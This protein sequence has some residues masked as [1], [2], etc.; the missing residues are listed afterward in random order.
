M[1]RSYGVAPKRVRD[2]YGGQSFTIRDVVYDSGIMKVKE[3]N[4]PYIVFVVKKFRIPIDKHRI[5]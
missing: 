1:V 4:L 3:E 5:L 2:L